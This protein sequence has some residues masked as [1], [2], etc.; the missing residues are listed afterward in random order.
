MLSLRS[1]DGMFLRRLFCA[2]LIFKFPSSYSGHIKRHIL[3]LK[4]FFSHTDQIHCFQFSV[5]R[6]GLKV[7]CG[8]MNAS[9]FY[10]KWHSTSLPLKE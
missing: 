9:R 8:Q 5:H 4:Y 3:K 2:I 7:S 10:K 6:N 1:E